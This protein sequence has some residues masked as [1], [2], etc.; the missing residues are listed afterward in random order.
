MN[1]KKQ[2]IKTNIDDVIFEY[3]ELIKEYS[4]PT[5]DEFVLKL[6]KLDTASRNILILF[7]A[8][9]YRY[10]ITARC[11]CTNAVWTKH[12]IEEIRNKIKQME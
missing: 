10:G 5:D 9:D 6:Q 7:I 11:L 12:K 8:S 2:S 1:R 3:R 4:Q